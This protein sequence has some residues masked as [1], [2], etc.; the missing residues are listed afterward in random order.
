MI[1]GSE[2]IFADPPVSALF[3]A[4]Y[5]EPRRGRDLGDGN[6]VGTGTITP[7]FASP[8]DRTASDCVSMSPQHQWVDPVGGLSRTHS[9]DSAA[10]CSPHHSNSDASPHHWVDP[11]PRSKKECE[12][13]SAPDAETTTA[14]EG[15]GSSH[16][17]EPE[18]EEWSSAGLSS[19]L[20]KDAVVLLGPEEF[21][22]LDN[23]SPIDSMELRE[24]SIK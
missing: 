1:E 7:L 6:S 17:A 24:I 5:D 10:Y 13:D 16:A 8:R 3:P 2:S 19:P 15:S 18:R 23:A 14:E 4:G 20:G 12:D 11:V 22:V 9:Q 21:S